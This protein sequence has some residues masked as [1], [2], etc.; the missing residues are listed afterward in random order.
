MRKRFR[1]P[2]IRQKVLREMRLGI[3]YKN[4]D[5]HD[6]MLLGFRLDSLNQRYRGKRLDEVAKMRGQDPDETVIDLV[7]LDKSTIAAVYYQQSEA[8]VRKIIQQSYVSFGSD[9]ASLSED[10]IF[11]EW[12]THPRAYG[13]FARVLGK[14]VREEKL[15]TLEEAVRRLTFLPATNLNIDDRGRIAVGYHA[16]I[17]IFNPDT[18][19]DLA[20]FDKPKQYAVGMVHVFVNGIQVLNNGQHTGEK[21]GRIIRGRGYDPIQ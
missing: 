16:D 4:S 20:T 17:A 18:I 15:M 7:L 2:A 5:P 9:G 19:V 3:P 1:N 14:Y 8:N 6:V 12:G 11:A 13:T 10:S 21:P